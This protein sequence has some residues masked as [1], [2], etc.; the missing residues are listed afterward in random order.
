MGQL[1]RKLTLILILAPGLV[2]AKNISVCGGL[3]GKSYFPNVGMLASLNEAE[4]GWHDDRINE[5][6]TTV[7]KVGD[8]FN[9]L[10]LDATGTLTSAKDD[11]AQIYPLP[12]MTGKDSFSIITFWPGPIIEIYSFWRDNDGQN[13]FSLSQVKGGLIHKQ[14]LLVGSCPYIDFSWMEE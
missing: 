6:K 4:T 7:T 12:Q 11:G 14:S 8:E 1:M 13:K 9:I 5:G 2:S 10:F 3:E